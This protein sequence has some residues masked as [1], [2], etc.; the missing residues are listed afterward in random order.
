MIDEI[1]ISLLLSLFGDDKLKNL[2]P[3]ETATGPCVLIQTVAR[4]K[5]YPQW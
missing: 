3:D 4:L 1:K 5:I 2:I